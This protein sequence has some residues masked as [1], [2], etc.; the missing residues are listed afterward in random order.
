MSNFKTKFKAMMLNRTFRI[1]LNSIYSIGA[2]VVVLGAL[3]K[4]QHWNGAGIMLTAG[5]IT[6]AVI[7]FIYAFEPSDEPERKESN[8]SESLA[9][10]AT[11]RIMPGFNLHG[12]FS[13]KSEGYSTDLGTLVEFDKM[14][15]DSNIT[16]ELLQKLGEGMQRLSESTTN[17]GATVDVREAS[18]SYMKTI[19]QANESLGKTA[20]SYEKVIND[21]I[22]KTVFKYKGISN[23]MGS[24]EEGALEFRQHTERFSTNIHDLNKIY[25]QQ[26]KVA[27]TY[28]KDQII[29]AEETV[30][31]KENIRELNQNLKE[32]NQIYKGMIKAVKVR[33]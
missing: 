21:V 27:E 13:E 11:T 23:A 14:L 5:L 8:N 10:R 9:V 22:L 19:Q 29:C 30:E 26:K 18:A 16:P 2:S 12:S 7:F 3:F 1:V 17:L 31:Y 20:N 28:L 25:A 6:E 32:L 33:G 4:I 24:I 15:Q